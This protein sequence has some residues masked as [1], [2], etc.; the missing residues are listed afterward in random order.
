MV[1]LQFF[2]GLLCLFSYDIAGGVNSSRSQIIVLRDG[3]CRALRTAVDGSGQE[4]FRLVLRTAAKEYYFAA[5]CD[6]QRRKWVSELREAAAQAESGRV[7]NN[8]SGNSR[9]PTQQRVFHL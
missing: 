8:G 1:S 9:L 3:L 6:E 2:G 4:R 5:G 7:G